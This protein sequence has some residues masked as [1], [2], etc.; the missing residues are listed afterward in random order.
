MEF[1]RNVPLAPRTT[2][3]VGGQASYFAVAETLDDI[4]EALAFAKEHTLAIFVLGGGSNVLLPDTDLQGLTLKI[5]LG[6]IEWRDEGEKVTVAVGAGESWDGLVQ[7]VCEKGY[8][9]IENLS[10]IPGSVGA[11][12]IQNVGAYGSEVKDVIEWVEALDK[13]SGEARRFS[14]AECRF[15]YR[16]SFFKSAEGMHFIVTR[17]SFVLAR[18]GSPNISYRDLAEFFRGN[19]APTLAEVRA[20]VL[21]I[22]SHKFPDLSVYGTAG[23]F[24]KNPIL[25][26]TDFAALEQKYPE[27]PRY[28]L[29]DGRVKVPLAWFLQ[30]LGWKGKREGDVG[31]FPNQPLVLVNYGGATAADVKG[32]AARVADDIYTKAGLTIEPE[33]RYIA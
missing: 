30:R 11:T 33:V 4:R 22:R 12:P 2:L 21:E 17:V 5:A 23:S 32:F 29:A 13:R 27:V 8:Y 14:N 7:V 31:T 10:G 25:D 9:G 1:L 26:V 3:R 19:A 20:A 24:F 28:P 6:G 18:A 16:D 15:A